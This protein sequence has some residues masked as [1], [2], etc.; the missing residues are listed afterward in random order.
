MLWPRLAGVVQILSTVPMGDWV[1]LD[2]Y[3]SYQLYVSIMTN[4]LA[5]V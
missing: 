4:G 5:H 3:L 2:T 1:L